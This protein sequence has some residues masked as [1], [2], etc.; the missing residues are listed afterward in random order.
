M[1]ILSLAAFGRVTACPARDK[2]EKLN[3]CNQTQGKFPLNLIKKP[4]DK[5]WENH[6]SSLQAGMAK[7]KG[8]SAYIVDCAGIHINQ[9]KAYARKSNKR[10]KL[11]F[12]M[13]DHI[14]IMSGDGQSP[15][16]IIGDISKGLKHLAKELHI[17]VFALAQLNRGVEART[18]KRPL[19]SDLRDSGSV[20]Q[21][22]DIIQ[23]LYREDYYKEDGS[24]SKPNDGLLEINTAKFRN[25]ERGTR[26]FEH[27]LDQ[28]RI[29]DT[30]RHITYEEPAK[31]KR[32]Y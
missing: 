22:A 3:Y 2:Q 26:V 6:S 27:H 13:V 8:K 5:F 15:T 28:S 14:H 20:E 18:N 7:L 9:V 31:I 4:N 1:L 32:G 29:E 12:I 17:P 23:L 11:D 21:D 24:G 30:K 10:K 16:H 25:G 19:I